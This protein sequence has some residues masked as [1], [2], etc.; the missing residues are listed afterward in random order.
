MFDK[1]FPL[2]STDKTVGLTIV[3]GSE[4]LKSLTVHADMRSLPIIEQQLMDLAAPALKAWVD[5]QPD[6]HPPQPSISSKVR[7][8]DSQP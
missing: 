6:P 2:G 8:E 1:T 4:G 7:V 3:G 5:S